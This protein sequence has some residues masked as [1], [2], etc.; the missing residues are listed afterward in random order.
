M[1]DFEHWNKLQDLF[2][3]AEESPDADLD[4]LLLQACD[5]PELRARA[6]SLIES[7]RRSSGKTVLAGTPAMPEKIG[8]YTLVRHLGAGGIGTVYL[9][10]RVIGRA[11]KRAALKVLLRTAAGPFFA[12]RFAREQHILSSLEHA[13]ITR[14]IDAGVS[15]TGEPYL[16]MEYV[17][18]VHLD[19][20]CDER[21]LGVT[22][23]LK[24]FLQVCEAISYAHRNLVVH[25]DLKPSNILV[26]SEEGAVKVLDF[27]TSKLILPDSLL[28]TTVMATPAYAS[29]EQLLNEPVTTVCDVYALG[30]I[31]FELLSGRR[32]NQDISVALLIERFMKELAPEPVTDAVTEA[33]AE[34]R[35]LTPSRL[36]GLLSGDLSTILSKC[37]RPRP[38]ERY[39]SVDALIADVQNYLEGR[40]ILARQ[41]TTT[42]LL[43]KFVRRNRKLVIMGTVAC[44]ALAV[45][46]GYAAWRQ[47]QAVREARRAMAM[48]TFLHTLFRLAN[49]DYTGK[50]T[51]TVPEFLQLGI[52][53]VPD[54]IGNGPDLRASQLSLAESM[55]DS[56]D[57]AHASVV[58]KQVIDSSRAAGDVAA[59][60]EAEGGAGNIDYT[61]GQVA[62]GK[63]LSEH[64]LALSHARGVSPS[65]RIRIEILY[66][67]NLEDAGFRTDQNIQLL[68]AA[69]AESRSS[70]VPE[71]DLAN[72]LVSLSEK[73]NPRGRVDEAEADLREAAAIYGGEPYALCDQSRALER[74]ALFRNQRKDFQGSLALMHQSYAGFA[75]CAGEGSRIALENQGYLAAAMLAAGQSQ[76]VI[77]MLE[78]SLPRWKALVGSD[79]P[80]L[81]TPL[82][83]L[84]RAYLMNNNF[85]RA[86]ET[87]GNLV[88]VQQGT[89]NPLSAQM[90][91]CELVLAQALAGQTRYREALPHAELSEA[92]FTKEASKSA[93]SQRNT[94]KAHALLADLQGRL[95]SAPSSSPGSRR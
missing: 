57:L 26:T 72:A 76:E 32:P 24:L 35:G 5:V 4:A 77:P 45:T 27:G 63:Q 44:L 86:E 41:Q 81:A 39:F 54:F 2:H 52:R 10:E 66:A 89:V 69:V 65:Q 95:A 84:A 17:D 68:E 91:V 87:A 33:A 53:V 23:R 60:A 78:A 90:G 25:L 71:H 7:G 3:K 73:L 16:V 19:V 51:A 31:L 75:A 18:G 20:Y 12:E 62:E 14:M 74:L 36:R 58:F 15:D 83:F 43:G 6:K 92:A 21:S 48:Q 49:P 94:A 56:G 30:A 13:S 93:G 28:T 67:E 11:V 38:K 50:P 46:L 79:S 9:V 29:P 85:T 34:R 70:H 40:P 80:E 64:A 47:Q 61:L 8:P 88:R 55:F 82:L 42:Y 22:E 59:E 37:L 1:D